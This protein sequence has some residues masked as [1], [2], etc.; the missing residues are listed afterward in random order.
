M[1]HPPITLLVSFSQKV[2]GCCLFKQQPYQHKLCN[3]S[4]TTRR[5]ARNKREIDGNGEVERVLNG[6]GWKFWW[7]FELTHLLSGGIEMEGLMGEE[8]VVWGK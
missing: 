8:G 3:H 4:R 5:F 7:V 2:S 1:M 6:K